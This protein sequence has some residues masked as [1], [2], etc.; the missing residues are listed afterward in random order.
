MALIGE[1]NVVKTIEN[2]KSK[3]YE[4]VEEQLK[5]KLESLTHLSAA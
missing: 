5:S 1:T 3:K 4:E 2:I